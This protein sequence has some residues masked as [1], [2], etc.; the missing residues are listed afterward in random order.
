ML[1][2]IAFSIPV[3]S[4]KEL[5]SLPPPSATRRLSRLDGSETLR[6]SYCFRYAPQSW[7]EW[8]RVAAIKI[9]MKTLIPSLIFTDHD[10]GHGDVYT[11][12]ELGSHFKEF[13]KFPMPQFPYQAGDQ[14]KMLCRHAKRLHYEGLLHL[15]Q[16]IATSIRFNHRMKDIDNVSS[17]GHQQFSQVMKLAKSAHLFAI[18]HL[19]EWRVR[20]KLEDRH[21]VLSE[22]ALKSAQ[23]KREKAQP[24]RDIAISLRSEGHTLKEISSIVGIPLSTIGRWLK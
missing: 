8:Q 11:V 4:V 21:K 17:R 3:A 5:R 10:Y 18:E 6:V 22:S 24:K 15:E 9:Q 2:G 13:V 23:V 19:G 16:L 1:W 20:M 12:S 7:K 14:Y